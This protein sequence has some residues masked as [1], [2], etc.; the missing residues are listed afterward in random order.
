[1]LLLRSKAQPR[2][3]DQGLTL[4]AEGI[5]TPQMN[6]WCQSTLIVL[7]LL[8]DAGAQTVV[9]IAGRDLQLNELATATETANPNTLLPEWSYGLR[10][11]V[12]GTALTLFGPT[13]HINTSSGAFDGFGISGSGPSVLVN[14]TGSTV[15]TDYGFGPNLGVT[16]LEMLLHPAANND[17]AV[18]RWTAPA[19]GNYTVSAYWHDEDP[20][21]GNGGSGDIV[22]N[23]AVVFSTSWANG[24][25]PATSGLLTL[26]LATGDRL[27]FLVG[28]AGDYAF[29]S[30]RFDA[31]ITAVPEPGTLALLVLGIAVLSRRRVI[32]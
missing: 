21:G 9:W 29:D 14:M 22:L 27:D 18:I 8:I 24:G 10:S 11:T 19:A 1:M 28:S 16:P 7:T 6:R 26:S 31:T 25:G 13:D 3:I 32:G 17:Y 2:P 20:H 30:T 4:R 5:E 12:T 23:G 15:I